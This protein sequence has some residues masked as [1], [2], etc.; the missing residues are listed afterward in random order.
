MKIKIPP[1]KQIVIYLLSI[2]LMILLFNFLTPLLADDFG[3]SF[4]TD[5]KIKNILDIV[6]YQVWHYFNWGGRTVAHFI[7]QL[8][9]LLPKWIFSICNSAVY[10]LLVYLIYLHAKGD[11]EENPIMIPIIHLFLWFSL[12]VFGQTFLWLIGSCNYLWTSVIILA[13]LLPFRKN[14]DK[15]DSPI[16][17]VTMFLIGII[18][19]WTNEN[20]AVGLI[21]SIAL[22][23]I[24]Y[25]TNKSKNKIKK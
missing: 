25:K 8:F 3:Y 15:K 10:V 12:P 11:K 24:C 13:F 18:A 19:G 9:L 20:S 14:I 21:V 2:F 5:G 23:I 17:I 7:A 1:K 4:G 22:L 16:L 6:G